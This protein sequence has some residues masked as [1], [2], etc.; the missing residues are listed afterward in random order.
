MLLFW[1]TLVP[2]TAG[3][4]CKYGDWKDKSI[5]GAILFL[6]IFNAVQFAVRYWS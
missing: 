5:I 4:D 1:L 3:I 2:I 6:I